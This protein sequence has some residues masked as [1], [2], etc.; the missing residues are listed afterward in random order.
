MSFK[1]MYDLESLTEAQRQEY[2]LAA[3]EHYRVPP[4]LNLLAFMYMDAG[5]GKRNLVLYAKKG[6]TDLMREQHGISTTKII[7][8]GGP[9]Y[10]A[11]IVEG[12][13]AKGRTEMAVGSAS[14]E[15]LKGQ[16][17]ANAVMIAHTRANRRLTLQ[18]VGGGLLDES[19]L[20]E[21]TTDI[22]RA[23]TPLSAMA[24]LPAP[25]QPVVNANTEAGKDVTLT[26]T[27]GL[28]GN[29]GI[30]G[31]GGLSGAFGP[32]VQHPLDP[33]GWAYEGAK[34]RGEVPE[35][36]SGG[37]ITPKSVETIEE[38]AEPRKRRTRRTKAEMQAAKIKDD[39][40]DNFIEPS[41]ESIEH[42]L[43]TPIL[44]IRPE[45]IEHAKES[46]EQNRELLQLL[47]SEYPT[48]E[49]EAVYR[50][51]LKTYTDILKSGGMVDGIIWRIRKYTMSLFP[52]AIIENGKL[53]LTAAQWDILLKDFGNIYETEGSKALI[54]K[55]NEVAE[56][57]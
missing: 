32:N 26:P 37:D 3:C 50:D 8:D 5:D 10:V 30:P 31:N 34:K 12:R 57:A 17:L 56:K 13:N 25:V 52:E 47:A 29:G 42:V 38:V 9:G 46:I 4:E 33:G 43:P 11:W 35:P 45:V 54:V 15:G 51:S 6:A 55:I 23:N 19:E 20:N 21:T 22:N 40:N 41:V 49:Q 36:F 48:K 44:E 28:P 53:K 24:T 39:T 27:G 7:K 1:P 14:I 2:Y 16:Q 18:F